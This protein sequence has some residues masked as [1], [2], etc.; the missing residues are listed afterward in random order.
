MIYTDKL[1]RIPYTTS[2]FSLFFNVLIN[3]LSCT[4]GLFLFFQICMFV[5]NCSG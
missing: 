3:L 2:M 1:F 4:K 5:L